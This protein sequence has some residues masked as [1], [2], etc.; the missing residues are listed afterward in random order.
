MNRRDIMI[1]WY[2]TSIFMDA[3][4]MLMWSC[5]FHG[6]HPDRWY[7][8]TKIRELRLSFS[9]RRS[10]SI[11]QLHRLRPETGRTSMF[12][13]SRRFFSFMISFAMCCVGLSRLCFWSRLKVLVFSSLTLLL[14]VPAAAPAAAYFGLY[15]CANSNNHNSRLVKQQI[16]GSSELEKMCFFSCVLLSWL[17]LVTLNIKRTLVFSSPLSL[18]SIL[19]R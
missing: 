13:L 10:S 3:Y 16:D 4:I 14:I 5:C 8:S 19:H 18:F 11:L 12:S 17:F 15:G 6:I 2:T 7:T 9:K 1:W